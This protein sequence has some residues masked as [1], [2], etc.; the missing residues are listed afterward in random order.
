M[1]SQVRVYMACSLDGC[2]AGPND[3]LG[4][5]HAPGPE[6]AGPADPDALGFEAFMAQVGAMLMGRRTFDIVQGMGVWPY[7]ETPVL[8][9][10]HRPLRDAPPT[11][12]A[13]S[14]TTAEVV[15]AAREAAGDKDVYVDGGDLVR[16][17]MAAGLVDELCLTMVP[18]IV[19]AGGVRLFDGLDATIPMRVVS[20]NTFEQGMVQLTMRPR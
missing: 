2:I 8:V 3:D 16:K 19:G 15:A 1:S 5:L 14:G 11:V 20:H 4:F 6:D 10:T 17:A 9:A 13:V 7:G 18:V 12:R